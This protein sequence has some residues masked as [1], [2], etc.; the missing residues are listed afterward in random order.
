MVAPVLKQNATSRELYLPQS[1]VWYNFW[2][3]EALKGAR[4]LDADAPLDRIPLFVRAGSI[5]PMGPE[6]QY[7]NQAPA[8]PID[9]RIYPGADGSFSLYKDSGDG[10]AY[11]K[12]EH[13]IIPIRWDNST[14]TL[15]IGARQ[16]SYPGMPT[17]MEFHVVLVRNGHGVGEGV[18]SMPDRTINYD[19][20]ETSV[21]VQP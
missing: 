16:G 21:K 19:G 11:Q 9:L 1:P 15:T 14:S 3:G 5:I 8:G 7:A 4:K 12:G 17:R 6:I 20:K 13:A 18:T 2:T 10:Y